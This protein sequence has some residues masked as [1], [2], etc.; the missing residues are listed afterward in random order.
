[1]W[2]N[3]CKTKSRNAAGTARRPGL[4]AMSSLTPRHFPLR[5]APTPAPAPQAVLI[6]LLTLRLALGLCFKPFFSHQ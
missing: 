5:H 3:V 4:T 6:D 1:M 2:K